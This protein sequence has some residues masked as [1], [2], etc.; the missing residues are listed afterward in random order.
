MQA[1]E[2]VQAVLLI[3]RAITDK[4]FLK[5]IRPSQFAF[6]IDPAIVSR[7]ERLLVVQLGQYPSDYRMGPRSD[8]PLQ[9]HLTAW[10]GILFD[11]AVEISGQQVKPEKF[12]V[13]CDEEPFLVVHK[14]LNRQLNDEVRITVRD[15]LPAWD[16]RY[17]YQLN[18]LFALSQHIEAIYTLLYGSGSALFDD[19]IRELVKDVDYVIGGYPHDLFVHH[20]PRMMGSEPEKLIFWKRVLSS[21]C[22]FPGSHDISQDGCYNMDDYLVTQCA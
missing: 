21:Y 14:A 2:A 4:R 19:A 17:T 3:A 22:V 1:N 18:A 20:T 5:S 12:V 16:N 13:R 9:D 7:L 10:S 15:T 11:M 8:A 6:Y